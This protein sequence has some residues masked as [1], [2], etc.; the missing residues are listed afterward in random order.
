MLVLEPIFEADLPPEQHAYRADR[1]ALTA[2]REVHRLLNTGHCEVVDADLAAYFDSIPQA[3]R[4]ALGLR[5]I[6]GE[7]HAESSGAVSV[8]RHH[9]VS[10]DPP[11]RPRH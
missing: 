11:A 9:A 1:N 10:E 6:G 5:G 8:R 4:A 2:V 3:H 7:E